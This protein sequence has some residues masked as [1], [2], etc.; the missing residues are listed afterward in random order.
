LK[1]LQLFF[2]VKKCVDWKPPKKAGRN[3]K[4]L[5]SRN[6]Y[7][8]SNKMA[9]GKCVICKKSLGGL[10]KATAY[11]CPACGKC[12]CKDCS[13]KKGLILKD[14]VSPCCGRILKEL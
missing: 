10:F 1:V 3:P 8:N 5:K 4:S 13:D 2:K 9:K 14:Y 7:F 6:K 12:Y 11:A